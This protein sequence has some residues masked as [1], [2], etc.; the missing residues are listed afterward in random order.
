MPS[1]TAAELKVALQIDYVP[2]DA[3]TLAIAGVEGL[4]RGYTGRAWAAV[5]AEEIRLDG[6]GSRSLLLPKLPV[7]NVVSITENPDNVDGLTSGDLEL[8][9]AIEWSSDGI[10]RRLD[11]GVFLR[12][13]RYYGVKYDHGEDWPDDVKLIV[14]RICARAVL[15]P[16]GLTQ[17][18]EGGTSAAWGFDATRL[19][20][21]S[22]PDKD[23]LEPYRVTV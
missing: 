17:E 7:R 6:N 10:V 21:L 23:D 8:G 2:D 5:N 20:T 19:A 12:R 11:G 9:T 22:Q 1:V 3:C 14:R 18:A 4:I 16:E 15:N 13:L